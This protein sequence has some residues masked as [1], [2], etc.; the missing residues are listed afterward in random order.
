MIVNKLL[1]KTDSALTTFNVPLKAIDT[2]VDCAD[3]WRSARNFI[4]QL[5][6]NFQAI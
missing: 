4:I 2:S 1:I 5:S 3:S 6:C